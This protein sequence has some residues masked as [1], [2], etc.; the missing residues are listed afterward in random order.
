MVLCVELKGEVNSTEVNNRCMTRGHTGLNKV[1]D[2]SLLLLLLTGIFRRKYKII[3]ADY[4]IKDKNVFTQLLHHNQDLLICW[5][6]NNFLGNYR[7]MLRAV[8]NNSL[9]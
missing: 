7:K 1:K 9:K 2:A 8:F 3:D 4:P 5:P 6:E